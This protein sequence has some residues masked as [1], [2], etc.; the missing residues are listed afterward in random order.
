MNE[1]IDYYNKTARTFVTD[2]ASADLTAIHQRFLNYMPQGA[3]I[4]DLG[5]G[6]GRDASAFIEAGYQVTAVD[7]S[8][9][10][11]R[12]AESLIGRPV[13]CLMFDQM[14][15]VNQFDGIWACASLLHVP[16]DE[17]PGIFARIVK[18]LRPGGSFYASFKYGE[19]EG[20]RSG[21][22]FTDMTEE[23]LEKLMGKVAGTKIVET[24]VT[25][26][27]RPGR[28]DEKWLNLVGEKA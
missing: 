25:G 7:G 21:R 4:L 9:A 13:T 8:E 26:D 23:R 28:E 1:T 3:S 10:C 6:S 2:T 16:F 11:C 14:D 18:A 19:F 12:L 17:L 20:F 22:Y 27:A 24:F 5:C 15:Y